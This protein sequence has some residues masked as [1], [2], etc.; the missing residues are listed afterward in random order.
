MKIDYISHQETGYFSNLIADY[1]NGNENLKSFYQF[2]PNDIGLE[3]AIQERSHF[4]VDRNTLVTVLQ[5]QYEKLPEHPLVQQNI[6]SLLS[7]DTFTVCTAHQPNL[8]T[9]YLYFFY[10]ILHAAHLTKHL[11]KQYPEKKFVPVFYIGSEDNDL[12]ELGVFRFR[13]Q[14]YRWDTQQTGAVGRMSTKDL[15]PLIERLKRD[16]GL[17]SENAKH[18]QKV[19]AAAY[20][21]QASIADATRSIIHQLLADFGIVVIDADDAALKRNFLPVLKTELFQPQSHDL[22]VN[23]SELLNQYYKAQAYS[24]EINLFYLIDNLRERI[25]KQGDAWIVVNTSIRWENEKELETELTQHPERF[26]PNVILRGL[27]QE[28][29]LPNV[30]F[31]G[32]GSEVAYWMQLKAVFQ[33]YHV[34]YPALILRQSAIWLGKKECELRELLDLDVTEMFLKKEALKKHYI[35][36]HCQKELDLSVENKK[37]S[38]LMGQMKEKCLAIDSSLESSAEAALAKMRHQFKI[39]EQKMI[40]AEKKNQGIAM[41][42]IEN[43]RLHAFP[44]ESLQERYDSFLAYYLDYGQSF[45]EVIFKNSLPYGD[46]FLIVQ[47]N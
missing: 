10:K 16:I 6:Q 20:E 33:H 39:L 37:I 26:S 43:F 11:S 15:L 22:V 4:E 25:E 17:S 29:I 3:K 19:I 46:Q 32:G 23:S 34:F 9:G 35:Y 47:D 7:K 27:Y 1:L 38:D 41:Q 13:N 8:L 12:E 40:R 18:L 24:R 5:K 36:H 28:S 2:E 42:R 45:F 30:A 31:I 44:N 21:G 14:K